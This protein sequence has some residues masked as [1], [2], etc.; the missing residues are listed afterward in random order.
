MSIFGNIFNQDNSSTDESVLEFAK[1]KQQANSLDSEVSTEQPTAEES[2]TPKE[3][4]QVT[5]GTPSEK[6]THLADWSKGFNNVMFGT[7]ASEGQAAVPGAGK[8]IPISQ[9]ISDYNA[10]AK[11]NNGAPLDAF[12]L[13][14][15]LNSYDATKS[16]ADNEKEAKRLK[17]QQTWEKI[18]SVLSHVGNLVGTIM[19]APSQNLE[20]GAAL[21][22]RQKK[23][24]DYTTTQRKQQG[25]EILKY[26]YQDI[27]NKRA[28]EI[29][30]ANAEYK[31]GQLAARQRA[32]DIQEFRA[33]TDK[34]FKD[35]TVEQKK[36]ILD[37]QR[38]LADGR[39]T[40]MQAQEKLA[41]VRAAAGGYAPTKKQEDVTVTTE[42][43]VLDP[44]TGEKKTLTTKRTTT[45]GASRTGGGKRVGW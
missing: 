37:I 28:Q 29:A 33:R 4:G 40:L 34:D 23:L 30:A 45:R 38:D 8:D 17:R 9:A 5:T 1:G 7:P 14:P 25:S 41:N 43:D 22:E 20:S 11:E 42:R 16:I 18:G 12:T 26:Y 15:M 3:T 32:L 44:L 27:A 6:S 35:A 10:W 2:S 36:Q 21:T 39:I 24:R 19:G 31:S 13:Y